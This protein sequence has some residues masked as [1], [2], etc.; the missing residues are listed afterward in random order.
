MKYFS[1]NALHKGHSIPNVVLHNA[2][3]IILIFSKN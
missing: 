2:L 1:E 3:F